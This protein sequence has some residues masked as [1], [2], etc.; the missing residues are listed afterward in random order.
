MRVLIVDDDAPVAE[1]VRAALQGDGVAA[2]VAFDL[3]QA[4]ALVTKHPYRAAVLDVNLPD[5]TGFE[6]VE[7]MRGRGFSAPVLLLTARRGTEDVVRG[8][9][10]GADDY[11][12]KPFA[13]EELTARV[14]ALLRRGAGRRETVQCGDLILDRLAHVISRGDRKLRL[15]PKEYSLLEYFLL[16]P[17]RVISRPELLEHVW[18]LHFDPGSNVVD[19]HVARLRAKL[20]RYGVTAR[21]ETVRGEGFVLMGD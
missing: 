18:D 17:A 1:F 11:L 12:S 20:V 9:D 15:T 10:A 4:E 13:V 2:D 8:L 5:G 7:R 3:S 6:F 14:R 16:N 19:T 21:L